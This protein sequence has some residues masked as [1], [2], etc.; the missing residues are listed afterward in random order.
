MQSKSRV[1][2]TM[3]VVDGPARHSST[4]TAKR[5]CA[6][7]GGDDAATRIAAA[8]NR[9]RIMAVSP[10]L[11]RDHHSETRSRRKWPSGVFG[12][13]SAH[14]TQLQLGHAGRDVQAGLTLD[15]DRLQRH[16]TI[17]AADQ[18]V[19]TETS[20]YG[21]LSGGTHIVASQRRDAAAGRR[22]DAPHHLA[23]GGGAEVEAELPDRPD[24][25][26]ARPRLGRREQ[27]LH[28]L[29]RSND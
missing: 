17:R 25:D 16:G 3:K 10:S 11:R 19:G 8:A 2:P 26:L 29:L 22:I 5:D 9:L 28:L 1:E 13:A 12:A 24:I 27:A 21:R 23:T 15:G 7:A 20:A 18:H 4:P 6:S 14:R